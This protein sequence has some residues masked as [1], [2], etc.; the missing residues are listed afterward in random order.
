MQPALQTSCAGNSYSRISSACAT[1]TN[2]AL[3]TRTSSACTVKASTPAVW[4]PASSTYVGGSGVFS[5]PVPGAVSVRGPSNQISNLNF[6]PNQAATTYPILGSLLNYIGIS[7][8]LITG[9]PID[10]A[11]GVYPI[12]AT[13]QCNLQPL[14]W[15]PIISRD[16]GKGGV[17]G[18]Q[19]MFI[20]ADTGLTS[21]PNGSTPGLFEGFVSN[22]V[23]VDVGLQGAAGN[24]LTIQDGAGQW[25]NSAGNMRNFIPFTTGESAYNAANA[26][27]GQRYAI[28]PESSIIPL[29]GTTALYFAPIIYCNVN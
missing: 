25:S 2:P 26:G 10:P 21:P 22:S 3:L 12:S 17:V 7:T 15:Q 5:K 4:P 28:W 20:F 1:I 13:D 23:A 9:Y 8:S 27:N 24:A 14:L 18:D 6:L 19:K 16:A 29:S 11:T